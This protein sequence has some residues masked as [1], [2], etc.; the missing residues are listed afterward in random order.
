M[1][2]KKKE[3]ELAAPDG[4]GFGVLAGDM[5]KKEDGPRMFDM[6]GCSPRS[7]GELSPSAADWEGRNTPTSADRDANLK[8]LV[9]DTIIK[10]N[11]REKV[12]PSSF[13]AVDPIKAGKGTKPKGFSP[14]T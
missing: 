4:T 2:R 14:R 12:P 13:Q 3:R 6:D 11:M 1:L 10:E 7:G 8:S 9:A 5:G